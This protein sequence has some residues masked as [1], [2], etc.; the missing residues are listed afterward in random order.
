MVEKLK[1]IS[2]QA[3]LKQTNKE[4]VGRHFLENLYDSEFMGAE[5]ITEAVKYQFDESVAN[6]ISQ[7][8]DP[9]DL[10]V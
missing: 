1:D 9:V 5:E 2:N 3:S 4:I 8:E 6:F 10:E 7:I